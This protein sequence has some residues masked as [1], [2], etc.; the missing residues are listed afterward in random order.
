MSVI[1]CPDCRAE[2]SPDL[3][4]K[5]GAARCPF[6]GANVAALLPAPSGEGTSLLDDEPG[7]ET[8]SLRPRPEGSRI[9]IADSTSDRLLFYIPG[10]PNPRARSLGFFALLWNSI[11]SVISFMMLRQAMFGGVR[12]RNADPGWGV[13]PF[14]GIFWIAG[15]VLLYGWLRLRFGKTIVLLEEHR[16]VIQQVLFRYKKIREWTLTDKSSAS[17]ISSY[18]ENKRPVYAVAVS[19]TTTD[20]KFGSALSDQEK[21]WL[22]DMLNTFLQ[23]EKFTVTETGAVIPRGEPL[24]RVTP[25][26]LPSDGL[27][28][29]E[30]SGPE[31]LRF[32]FPS[33]PR[34]AH[35][36]AVATTSVLMIFVWYGILAAIA[37]AVWHAPL[38][39]LEWFFPALLLVGAA[40]L[41]LIVIVLAWKGTITVDFDAKRFQCRYHIG[42]LGYTRNIPT[43]EIQ[44]IEVS[45]DFGVPNRVRPTPHTTGVLRCVVRGRDGQPIVV[46]LSHPEDFTRTLAALLQTRLNELR[47]IPPHA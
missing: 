45:A 41:P 9:E 24:P 5:A 12:G 35:A 32:Y 17:L 38:R 27:I 33:T 44:A 39:G 13:V 31:R 26:E 46:T 15:V 42:A 14:L 40:L 25:E 11:I 6:C 47:H 16:I 2:I 43:E 18:E 23:P 8:V 20:A 37:F 34:E 19:T 10:T 1:V 21:D 3:E 30:E 28:V 22:V 36:P 7:H 29:L 4:Q